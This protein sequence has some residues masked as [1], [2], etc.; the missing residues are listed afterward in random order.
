MTGLNGPITVITGEKG[1][2]KSRYCLDLMEEGRSAG[3]SAAGF[4]SPAVYVD[5]VKTAFYTM[6]VRTGEQRLCGKRTAADRGTVGCWQMDPAVLEWGNELLR[7]SCPCG[8]LFIDELGPLE[9]RENRGYTAAFDVLKNGGFAQAYV[10][11]RPA[12][13]GAFRLIIP[14]F[15]VITVEKRS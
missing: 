14:K 1:A 8:L 2:G 9:F 6:D 4:I 15:D 7:G 3:R 13:I 5:G 11:V 10:V 12:C